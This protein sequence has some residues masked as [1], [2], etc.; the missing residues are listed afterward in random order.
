MDEIKKIRKPSL[1]EAKRKEENAL[2]I[3]EIRDILFEIIKKSQND[4]REEAKVWKSINFSDNSVLVGIAKAVFKKLPKDALKPTE[5]DIKEAIKKWIKDQPKNWSKDPDKEIT[6]ILGEEW[7]KRIRKEGR[8]NVFPFF[9]E[10]IDNI[11]KAIEQFGIAK[12][13]DITNISWNAVTKHLLSLDRNWYNNYI[14][15][16]DK[17]YNNNV[18]G[19]ASYLRNEGLSYSGAADVMPKGVKQDTLRYRM[20]KDSLENSPDKIEL[21]RVFLDLINDKSW[22]SDTEKEKFNKLDVF[23]N[24]RILSF[25]E[26]IYKIYINILKENTEDENNFKTAIKK[27]LASIDFKNNPGYVSRDLEITNTVGTNFLSERRGKKSKTELKELLKQYIEEIKIIIG[28]YNLETFSKYSE[29]NSDTLSELLFEIDPK[30]HPT[31]S[32]KPR[33]PKEIEQKILSLRK[34][35][36]SFQKIANKLLE[37]DQYKISSEGV[38]S[39]WIKNNPKE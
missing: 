38:R 12:F 29:I 14:T 13:V 18:L 31:I 36:L 16:N 35:G 37:E 26:D 33:I 2:I 25:I 28:K 21:R 39:S 8:N 15:P 3:I 10:N 22:L 24:K 32:E 11:K 7:L 5:E 6:K 17:L 9:E 34:V 27:W 23:D 19:E 20:K 30:W 1:K 4:E